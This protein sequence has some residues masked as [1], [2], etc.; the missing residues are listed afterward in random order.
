MSTAGRKKL[1][2]IVFLIQVYSL[3]QGIFHHSQ[4]VSCNLQKMYFGNLQPISL[5]LN[6][7]SDSI[8]DLGQRYLQ[9][10]TCL[11]AH[12]K[13]L[14]LNLNTALI[15]FSHSITSEKLTGFGFQAEPHLALQ[16]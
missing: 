3:I 13:Q 2:K 4:F 11:S 6:F 14:L 7:Y 15:C 5:G 1:M 8:F 9:I 10:F 12:S 16:I